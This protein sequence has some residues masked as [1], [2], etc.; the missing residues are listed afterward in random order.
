VGVGVQGFGTAEP[1]S[2]TVSLGPLAMTRSRTAARS[3]A[4]GREGDPAG[5][6]IDVLTSDDAGR[7][8]VEPALRVELAGEVPRVLLVSRA[9]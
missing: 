2:V 4:D 9:A 1:G 5:L 7:H 3:T 6:W 8:L